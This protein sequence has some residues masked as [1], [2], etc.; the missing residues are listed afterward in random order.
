VASQTKAAP[1]LP[2]DKAEEK[3]APPARGAALVPAVASAPLAT[4]PVASSSSGSASTVAVSVTS[5]PAGAAVW[6]NGEERG[7]TPCTVKL[8]SGTSQL[9][10][11]K[12]GHVSVT[13]TFE[14]SAGKTVEQTLKAVDPPL[15]GEARFRAECKTEGKLPI[16][17]D[18]RETGVFC[19][20]SKLRVEPGVHRIGV[21]VPATGKVHEKELTL[22]AGV[23]SIVFG[24]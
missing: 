23:R 6:I 24:D 14:A 18:G 16:V 19:P 10:L 7:T 12:A 3:A 21:L 20:Y 22:S 4:K 5:N 9:M 13:S 2:T 8:A 15:A 11:V 1:T 17:I